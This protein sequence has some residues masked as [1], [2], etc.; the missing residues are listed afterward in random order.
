MRRGQNLFSLRRSFLRWT[1]PLSRDFVCNLLKI[2]PQ[3]SESL[4]HVTI[5]KGWPIAKVRQADSDMK[6]G[7][8]RQWPRAGVGSV[9]TPK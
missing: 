5:P 8:A 2:K 1:A 9:K 3:H 4:V 7:L 6:L